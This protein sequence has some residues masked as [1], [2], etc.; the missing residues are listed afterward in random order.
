[1]YNLV[2][3]ITSPT[4]ITKKSFRLIDAIVI[5]MQ[6]YECY[7]DHMAQIININI[8]RSKRGPVKSRKRQFTT[9][10]IDEFNYLLQKESWQECCF[11]FRY[12]YQF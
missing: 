9:E 8:N 12:K 4:R 7:S 6:A 10:S 2:N 5:N 11:K 1:M 3:T